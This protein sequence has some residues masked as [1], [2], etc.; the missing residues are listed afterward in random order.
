M[1]IEK[2]DKKINVIGLGPGNIDYMTML[3]IKQV[4]NSDV[5][6]GSE[7][8]L[9]DIESILTDKQEKYFLT[10]LD[11]LIIFLNDKIKE[12][13]IISIV[14]SGDTG[15]YSL[16]P[17]LLKNFSKKILNI[18]PGISSYQYLFSKIGMN[19]QNFKLGSLHGRNFDYLKHLDDESIEGLILL[20]DNKN[21]PYTIAKT[22][23]ENK[24]EDIDIIIGENLSYS[25]EK[26]S[27]FKVS[28]F[29]KLNRVFEMNV[30]VLKKGEKYAYL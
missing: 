2:I 14:V 4:K 10:K 24:F 5:V 9:K 26:I 16:V 23:Y 25:N 3:G 21:T 1:H 6:V 27:F 20:T 18:T 11:Q 7:R 29:E 8:Q 28:E 17:Y 22:L 19:W 12:N 13:K 15:F 30:V